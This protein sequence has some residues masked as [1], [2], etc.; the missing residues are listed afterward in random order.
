[1]SNGLTG[2]GIYITGL[3]AAL[4]HLGHSISPHRA[5]P[6]IARGIRDFTSNI[7]PA[8]IQTKRISEQSYHGKLL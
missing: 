2:V 6:G 5:R 4:P 3:I 7:A 1:M 8:I